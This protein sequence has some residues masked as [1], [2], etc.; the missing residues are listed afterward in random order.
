MKYVLILLLVLIPV[1]LSAIEGIFIFAN[2]GTIEMNSEE[3]A[4]Y[5]RNYSRIDGVYIDGELVTKIYIV[6]KKKYHLNTPG[7]FIDGY[8]VQFLVSGKDIIL[9]NA[10]TWLVEF[11]FK[12]KTK[13]K[14]SKEK[15][16]DK[17]HKKPDKDKLKN[18]IKDKLKNKP[19]QIGV[20]P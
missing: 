17:D 2:D 3:I 19:S 13:P 16:D 10:D 7:M 20:K 18:K 9:R 11:D 1:S 5:E 8:F 14:R 15:N 6:E 4:F 12:K